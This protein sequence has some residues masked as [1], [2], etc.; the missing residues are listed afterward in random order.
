MR[1]VVVTGGGAVSPLGCDWP[2]IE[3]SLRAGRS[4]IIPCPLWEEY[5]DL[6]SRAAGVVSLPELPASFDRKK[7]RGMSR[8]ALLA[9]YAAD[10]ALANAEL[11]GHPVITGGETGVACGSCLGGPEALIELAAACTRR[12]FRGLPATT[13]IKVMSH[14]CAANIGLF[15]GLTGRIIPTCS[16]CT[17]GSQGI[18]F[19]WESIRAGAQTVML[20]GGAEELCL[21][22]TALFD[23]MLATSAR[24]AATPRPF[25]AG[26]DGLV[27][28]EGAAVLVLEELEHALAR[29]APIVAELVGF[30]TNSD[31]AHLTDPQPETMSRA[32]RLSLASAGL[33]PE[34][35]GFVHCHAT[36]TERGDIAESRATAAVFG[37]T[38]P[39]GALKSY[40]GHTLG[41]AG[42]L[43]SWL[44]I[45]MMN[46][47][48]FAPVLNLEA[49][50]TRCAP[51]AWITGA[52][53]EIEPT[54][55][56]VNN[57]A[58]GGVNTS[59]IFKRWAGR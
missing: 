13:F 3:A 47:G 52:G 41:A 5:P 1:R 32:M 36:G 46:S 48:W 35:I 17:S 25:D 33:R 11:T 30:G 19:A 54:H 4:G 53:L 42:A 57:F 58:F 26:R 6:R 51:L 27:T 24:S 9:V 39:V 20:A 15:F 14:S 55:V 8:A 34:Q 23:T 22:I 49:P 50:D 10:L 18:G 2:V 40:L 16:A 56:M 37:S 12:Q 43:E 44:T 7:I 45:N 28:A 21:G 59:L 29:K 31:G 38:T